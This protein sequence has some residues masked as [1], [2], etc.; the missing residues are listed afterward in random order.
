MLKA[1]T[2]DPEEGSFADFCARFLTE[3]GVITLPANVGDTVYCI[4]SFGVKEKKVTNISV[5]IS[6]DVSSA[7]FHLVDKNGRMSACAS[8]DF[9]TYVFRDKKNAEAMMR[10]REVGERLGI[11]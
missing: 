6:S 11:I 5:L 8:K 3:N 7:I 1:K 10:A 2:V 4:G 9:E